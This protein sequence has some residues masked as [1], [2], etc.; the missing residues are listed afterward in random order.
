MSDT[1][2]DHFP[3]DEQTLAYLRALSVRY[4]NTDATLA[5]IANLRAALTLPKGAIHVI[6]DIHGEFKKLIH[7][8]K[9][10]SG[11]FASAG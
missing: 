6:S 2:P 8:I 5:A 3:P 1:S 11:C 9:N 7:V 10:A 4:P